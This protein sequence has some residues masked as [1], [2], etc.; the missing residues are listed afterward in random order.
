MGASICW[1]AAEANTHFANFYMPA[2]EKRLLI[3]FISSI[4]KA[5]VQQLAKNATKFKKVNLNKYDIPR[6]ILCNNVY[7]S[8]CTSWHFPCAG[9]PAAK[10][11][12]I[13]AEPRN[14]ECIPQINL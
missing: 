6:R 3:F 2:P 14:R 10:V 4:E 11:L 12:Q 5:H 1:A 8:P 7:F 9:K 13:L